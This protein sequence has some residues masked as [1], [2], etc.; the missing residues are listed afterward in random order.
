MA[1]G[2]LAR[3]ALQKIASVRT[4]AEMRVAIDDYL[5]DCLGQIASLIAELITEVPLDEPLKRKLAAVKALLG[6]CQRDGADEAFRRRYRPEEAMVLYD[7]LER[8]DQVG[9]VQRVIE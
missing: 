6:E 1:N 3:R 9:P 4:W 8:V 2:E 5:S 7:E